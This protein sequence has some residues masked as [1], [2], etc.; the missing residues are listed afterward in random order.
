[1]EFLTGIPGNF[2]DSETGEQLK[3]VYKWQDAM[4]FWHQKELAECSWSELYNFGVGLWNLQMYGLMQ[5]VSV[6]KITLLDM[7]KI[8]CYVWTASSLPIAILILV[9]MFVQ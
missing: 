1:M 6:N 8:M 9:V 7:V 2:V 3:P 5:E 4:G